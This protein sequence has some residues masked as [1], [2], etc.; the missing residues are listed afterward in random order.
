[1]KTPV[2]IRIDLSTREA[3]KAL[4]RKGESYDAVIQRIMKD[5]K[6]LPHTFELIKTLEQEIKK[7]EGG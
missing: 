7:K 6:K 2:K 5:H 3:L 4:G 1:M